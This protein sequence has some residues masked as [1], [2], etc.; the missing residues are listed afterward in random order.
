MSYTPATTARNHQ[1]TALVR[2]A[3]HPGQ[4]DAFALLMEMGTGKSKVVVD[5]WGYRLDANDLSDLLIFAPAGC[6]GNWTTDAGP[7]EPC[8]LHKHMDP[9]WYARTAVHK[10]R[11][12][13][14]VGAT[15]VMKQFIAD[16]SRPRVLVVNIEAMSMTERAKEACLEFIRNSRHGVMIAVDESTIIKNRS[17]YCT[18]ALIELRQEPKVAAVRILTGLVTP[19]SPLDLFS[20][21]EFLDWRILGFQTFVGFRA[22]YAVMRQIIVSPGGLTKA[23][24]P[25]QPRKV[26]L[27]VAYRN[28][29]ELNALIA[30]HSYR[31]LKKDC[32][33]LPEKIYLPLRHVELTKEQKRIYA[34]VKKY[35]TSQLDGEDYVTVTMVLT[36]RMRLDQVL[37]GFTMDESNKL[38]EIPENR[39]TE[40]LNLLEDYEG[41]AIIWTTHDYCIRKISAALTK[42]YKANSVAQFWGGNRATRHEDERRFKNDPE[43]RFIVATQSAGGRGNTWVGA[44]LS[45]Y[46]NNN[47]NLEHRL[48]SEDRNHR[49]GLVGPRG[50]GSATYADL[51]ADGTIDNDKIHNLRG[52][53]DIATLIQGDDYR[54]WLI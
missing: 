22:R 11:S 50:A 28:V 6:Y 15:A 2:I 17:A 52:K 32:L 19:N 49:D 16:P 8:E 30:P 44:A 31:V 35:A 38:H 29:D 13:A 40:L 54:K 9:E 18:Q 36:Q 53:L 45:I 43:C 46:Y 21:F 3:E 48:Q 10:W 27:I 7:D 34:E 41:K 39:T 23:G 47:D 25:R 5:E 1:N 37:C 14:G 42:R 33:D 12:G 24:K 26:P 20:Q 51:C 4:T